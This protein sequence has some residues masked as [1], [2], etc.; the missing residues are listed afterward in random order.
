M[1]KGKYSAPR[2]RGAKSLA[3]ILAAVLTVGCVAGGTLAWLTATTDPISN[4]FV[5]GNI[6]LELEET[7][8]ISAGEGG[9]VKFVPGQTWEKDTTVTVK[10]GSEGCYLFLHIEEVNNTL[11]DSSNEKV[12]QWTFQEEGWI[13]LNGYEGYYYRTVNHSEDDDKFKL[14]ADDEL[15]V[16]PN[17]TKDMVAQLTGQKPSLR[18][19]AAAIQRGYLPDKNNDGIVNE[20][21]AWEL[22]PET[23]KYTANT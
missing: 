12:I 16:S 9:E 21:D 14:I 8:G 22:L 19:T 2:K 1:T 17:V 13:A 10:G 4:T 18:F 11:P 7:K 20:M 5:V 6:E 15:T 3:V 23:F